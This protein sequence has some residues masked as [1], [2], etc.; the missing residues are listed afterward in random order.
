[1]SEH[2]LSANLLERAGSAKVS[3]NADGEDRMNEIESISM[4]YNWGVFR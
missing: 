1:V 4:D 2:I 3:N